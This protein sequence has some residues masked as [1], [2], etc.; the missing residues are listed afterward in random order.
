MCMIGSSLKEA[1][2]YTALNVSVS[3]N[4][5]AQNNYELPAIMMSTAVTST[6]ANAPLRLYW[7]SENVTLGYYVYMHFAEIQVLKIETRSFNIFVNGN[8]QEN[9]FE[10]RYLNTTTIRTT[11]PLV[12]EKLN[13]YLRRPSN[14]PFL[15]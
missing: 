3:A 12:E 13:L 8:P 15:P 14:Q 7:S 1:V 4:S 6:N 9:N 2:F 11:A 5:N 10:P